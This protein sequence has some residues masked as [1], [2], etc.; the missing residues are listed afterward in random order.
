[1]RV[2]TDG[3]IPPITKEIADEIHE[4]IK[5]QVVSGKLPMKVTRISNVTSGGKRKCCN[6]VYNKDGSM[7]TTVDE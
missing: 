3:P 6:S 4:I 2:Y 7:T 1:M 5:K